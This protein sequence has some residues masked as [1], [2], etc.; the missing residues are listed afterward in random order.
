MIWIT[1]RRDLWLTLG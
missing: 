1:D